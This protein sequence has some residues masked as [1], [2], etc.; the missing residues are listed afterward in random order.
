MRIVRTIAE[1]ASLGGGDLGF[2]P[3]M[4]AF[5]EGHLML[6][7]EARKQNPRV[8]VSLF[9]NPLQFGPNEDFDRYPRDE[10]RDFSLASGEGID[11]LFAPGKDELYSNEM[12]RIH[13]PNLGDRWEGRSRPGHFDGVA[14]I[15]AK[16]FNIVLP[17]N[18][19][20]GWKDLQQCLVVSRLVTDLALPV[21]LNFLET[22]REQ[23]GL[24]MS[25]RNRYLSS[26]ERGIAPLLRRT[27]ESIAAS[28]R[29]E[30]SSPEQL[31]ADG[32][33][34]LEKSGFEVEYLELVSLSDLQI[35]RQTSD[36]ALIIA[37]K[38][39]TTRLIDN[40]RLEAT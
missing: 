18:A 21:R 33:D 32:R 7:R 25:S 34:R 15:V 30:G 36:A 5:H 9:V 24:A 27:L 8:C 1:M 20:F 11:Y 26:K 3:T 17:R 31:I 23:D 16:L 12:T 38:L 22:V 37:A 28:I 19:Y 2:V 4:G 10:E 6:M 35:V 13:V 39:G 29:L 14:T 40:L